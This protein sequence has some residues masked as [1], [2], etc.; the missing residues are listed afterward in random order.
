MRV[1][2][3]RTLAMKATHVPARTDNA[4]RWWADVRDAGSFIVYTRAP[5]NAVELT[6]HLRYVAG[7]PGV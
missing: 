5:F 1:Q 4:G 3:A 2:P 6:G 7:Q